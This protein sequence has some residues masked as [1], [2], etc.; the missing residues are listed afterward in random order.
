MLGYSEESKK[1]KSYLINIIPTWKSG[2]N[3]AKVKFNPIE[4]KLFNRNNWKFIVIL[5]ILQI[6][7]Y[8]NPDYFED[9]L[10]D[11]IEITDDR[12]KYTKQKLNRYLRRFDIY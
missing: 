9:D 2:L 6:F 10:R 12:E 7:R 3:Y 1:G 4:V 11:I 8:A 5:S